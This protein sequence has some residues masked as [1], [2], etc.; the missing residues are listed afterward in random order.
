MF[1]IKINF[2]TGMYHAT[3]WGRNVN[4]GNPEWP[5]SPYRLMRGLFDV[6]KRK[7]SSIPEDDVRRALEAI[8]SAPPKYFLPPTSNAHIRCYL[9]KNEKDTKEKAL[10]LDAFTLIDRDLPVYLIWEEVDLDDVQRS[11][12]TELLTD[13]NFLG[14]SE[15]W[16]EATLVDEG[17]IRW[18]SAPFDPFS[19]EEIDGHIVQV[20][21]AA[22]NDQDIDWLKGLTYGTGQMIKEGRK[23]PPIIRFVDYWVPRSILVTEIGTG[24]RSKNKV[25]GV[26]YSM[27]SDLL[28]NVTEGLDLAN[29]VHVRLMGINKR[30]TDEKSISPKFSGKAIDSSPLKGHQHVFILPLDLNSDLLLDHLLV[31][32]HEQLNEQEISVLDQLTSL[33]Q[34]GGKEDIRLVPIEWGKIGNIGPTGA[35][36]IFESATPF[37]P[38]RF[39]RKGRG[40]FEEWLKDEVRRECQNVGLPIPSKIEPIP[41]LRSMSREIKWYQFRRSRRGEEE[42]YGMGFRIEFPHDV[43][44]P[45]SLGYASHFGLGLF[46]PKG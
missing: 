22:P 38:S 27:Q 45:V 12:L 24:T 34:S 31:I 46:M 39:F 9:S 37:V 11:V 29:Q 3:P 40:E 33:Y 36:R 19:R 21:C 13:L 32:S 6:W 14:R 43:D 44:G 18:N 20:A 15:S 2:Q 17:C 42:R 16:V 7:R 35:A 5:P 23:E 1:A 30:L 10:I 8:A 25:N 4:E 41:C 26:L 28:P